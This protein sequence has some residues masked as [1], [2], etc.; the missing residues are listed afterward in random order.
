MQSKLSSGWL[1]ITILVTGLGIG[2]LIGLSIS[3]VVSIVITSVTGAA[4]AIIAVVSGVEDK[5]D[6]TEKDEKRRKLTRNVNPTP[7]ALLVIGIVIGSTLG[8]WARN[9]HLLGSDLSSEIKK[10]TDQGF[11][12]DDVTKKLFDKNFVPVSSNQTTSNTSSVNS[13]S[14]SG[15]DQLGTFLFATNATECVE[16][17]AALVTSRAKSDDSILIRSLKS[18]RVSQLAQLPDVVTDTQTLGDVVEKVICANR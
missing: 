17:L 15:N 1:A 6:I 16:L 2:W 9:Y 3:P 8:I 10:W 12:K 11:T 18:S 14:E 5:I 13:N 4:A 7:L